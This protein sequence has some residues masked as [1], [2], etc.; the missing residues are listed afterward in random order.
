MLDNAMRQSM[1]SLIVLEFYNKSYGI[2]SKECAVLAAK[3]TDLFPTEI[4]SDYYLKGCT[5]LNRTQGGKIISAHK[6]LMSK[7]RRIAKL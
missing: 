7:I 1:A 6:N 2:G 3:I 4:L 5:K